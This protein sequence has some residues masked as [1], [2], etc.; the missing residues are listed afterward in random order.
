MPARTAPDR[1][2]AF[3]AAYDA[4]SRE[5]F[6]A[7]HAVLRDTHLAEDVTNEVFLGYW[8]RPEAFDAA[9]GELG[10][11]LRLMAKSRALGAWRRGASAGRTQDRLESEAQFAAPVAEDASEPVQRDERATAVRAAVRRLPAAQREA[12]ALAY[13]G[14]MTADEIARRSGAPLGTVKS[15]IRLGLRRI[16][17]EDEGL[18]AA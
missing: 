2:A 13:W 15:R 9:R 5:V 3:E 10:A 6:R 4:H 17:R 1:A 11:Y 16:V 12:V 14:E 8:R 18:A 7:A